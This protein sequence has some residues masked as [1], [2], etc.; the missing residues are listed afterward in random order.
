MA[1]RM[2]C[3]DLVSCE[4]RRADRCVIKRQAQK[5]TVNVFKIYEL[6]SCV[7]INGQFV[8]DTALG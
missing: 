8:T 5:A 7:I 6:T 2:Y 3:E 4:V 1:V